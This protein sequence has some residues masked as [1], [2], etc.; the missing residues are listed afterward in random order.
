MVVKKFYGKTTREALRQ[1]RDELGTDALILSNRSLADGGVEIMAVADADVSSLA[2]SLASHVKPPPRPVSM[3]PLSH[4]PAQSVGPAAPL[5][6]ALART[7]ALPV[8]PPDEPVARVFHP[9]D[10]VPTVRKAD[11]PRLQTRPADSRPDLSAAPAEPNFVRPLRSS[12][13]AMPEELLPDDAPASPSRTSLTPSQQASEA[14]TEQKLGEIGSEMRELKALLTAQMASLA[15]AN[16]EDYHPKQA[17]LFRKLLTV[18]MSPALCRQLVSKLPGHFDEEAALKWAKSALIHNLRVLPESDDIVDKGGVYALV[19]PTGVGKTTTIAKLA[20]RATLRKGADAV[21]LIT[22]DSYRIGAQDQLKLY[23]RILQIS[24]YAV[25]N[26]ADLALTLKDLSHKHLVLIDSVGI[27]QRDPRL[28]GQTQMYAASGQGER[29]IR[30][31]LVLA[32]NAA[33]HTLQDVIQRYQG[34]GLVGT[35]ISKLDES[36]ALGVA[37]DVAIRHRLPVFYIANGQRVPED[38]HLPDAPYLIERTFQS[39]RQGSGPF[40]YQND[41]YRILQGAQQPGTGLS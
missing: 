19:G 4:A 15:W 25:D 9:E 24:V 14:R 13:P 8:E 26:E 2:S 30:R 39:L 18:G 10:D 17:E 35:I 31:I 22:T 34:E 1:V 27:G 6:S 23:G 7:Y 21:A 40:A 32:A 28:N 38:L 12:S 33:G 29:A 37:L 3:P 16:L 11:F 20:A 36:P 41:E 5:A